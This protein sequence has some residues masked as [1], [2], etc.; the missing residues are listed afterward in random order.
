MGI[1]N[2]INAKSIIMVTRHL[3]VSITELSLTSNLV[4]MTKIYE[5]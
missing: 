2:D 1:Q 3:N 5:A 4:E